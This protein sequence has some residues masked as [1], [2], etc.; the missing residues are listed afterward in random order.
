M[1]KPINNAGNQ[2]ARNAKTGV[3]GYFSADELEN[4][5]AGDD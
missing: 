1:I 2:T 4:V 3:I 5:E